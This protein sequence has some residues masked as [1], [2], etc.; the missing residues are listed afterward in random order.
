MVGFC[1]TVLA[2]KRN[3]TEQV[4]RVALEREKWQPQIP[5]RFLLF[6]SPAKISASLGEGG[7]S[8]NAEGLTRF[9]A[10]MRRARKHRQR[11]REI[12]DDQGEGKR[13]ERRLR[14]LAVRFYITSPIPLKSDNVANKTSQL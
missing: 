7:T 10:K 6:S 11:S 14:Q 9:H 2:A 4:K 13:R 1:P 8:E 5:P 3:S 12:P